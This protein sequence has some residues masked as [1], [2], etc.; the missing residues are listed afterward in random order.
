MIDSFQILDSK[1]SLNGNDTAEGKRSLSNGANRT[2]HFDTYTNINLGIKISYPQEWGEA[3][4]GN[5][6]VFFSPIRG[7]YLL[8]QIYEIAIDEP[9]ITYDQNADYAAKLGWVDN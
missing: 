1:D 8:G 2:D 4:I 5:A 7:P 9:T 6:P 3:T